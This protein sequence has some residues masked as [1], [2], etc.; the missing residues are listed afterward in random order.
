MGSD[1]RQKGRGSVALKYKPSGS[2]EGAVD[3]MA[4]STQEKKVRRGTN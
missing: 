2:I 4:R 3:R 1:A